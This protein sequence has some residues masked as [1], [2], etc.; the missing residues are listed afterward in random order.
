MKIASWIF[1]VLSFLAI[2]A[3]FL[4]C[5]I[6]K[7][8][9]TVVE[10]LIIGGAAFIILGFIAHVLINKHRLNHGG[11]MFL[12]IV[13]FPAFAIPFIVLFIVWGILSLI[14]WL[15]Y[16][17]TDKYLISDFLNW[18]KRDV[19]GIGGG[20]GSSKQKSEEVYAVIENGFER[21]L[22]FYET[23]QDTYAD[24]PFYMEY[25]NRFRDDTGNFWRSYDNNETFV[26]ETLEQTGRGY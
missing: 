10:K 26:K 6:L 1:T 5:F 24:S 21:L 4:L 9:D 16:V 13:T 2:P 25:Y 14:N 3:V 22:S 11:G 23:K 18:I 12:Y 20:R 7:T 8:D 19:L 17:F 15:C